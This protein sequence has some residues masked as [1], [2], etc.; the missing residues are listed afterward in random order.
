M[1]LEGCAWPKTTLVGSRR[2]GDVRGVVTLGTA[3]R[4]GVPVQGQGRRSV[5]KEANDTKCF[6]AAHYMCMYLFAGTCQGARA[7]GAVPPVPGRIAL[8]A[9]GLRYLPAW[10]GRR[11]RAQQVRTPTYL[12]DRGRGPSNATLGQVTVRQGAGPTVWEPW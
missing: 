12:T 1:S 5:R 8:G 9:L 11:G 2:S 7:Y 4:Y 6:P 10:C 3:S